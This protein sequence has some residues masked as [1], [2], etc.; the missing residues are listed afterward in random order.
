MPYLRG[1]SASGVSTM[2]ATPATLLARTLYSLHHWFTAVYTLLHAPSSVTCADLSHRG[3]AVGCSMI[4]TCCSCNPRVA[5]SSRVLPKS[6]CSKPYPSVTPRQ[7]VPPVSCGA[8][9]MSHRTYRSCHSSSH[10]GF[11][12]LPCSSTSSPPVA[13]DNCCQ[14]STHWNRARSTSVA[15]GGTSTLHPS[16][17]PTTP[18]QLIVL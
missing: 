8:A 2:S 15:R 1:G 10:C 17:P 4:T 12:R 9:N 6:H 3:S 18:P 16:G 14:R 7:A 11:S 13:S 5:R